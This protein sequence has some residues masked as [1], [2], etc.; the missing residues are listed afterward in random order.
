MFILPY[1]SITVNTIQIKFEMQ[2]ENLEASLTPPTPAS[3]LRD[4]QS[5]ETLASISSGSSDNASGKL[6][7]G[8]R[9]VCTEYEHTRFAT[10]G[11]R[12][13]AQERSTF[14]I[15]GD[16]DFFRIISR[17]PCIQKLMH[18]KWPMLI[19]QGE[20]TPKSDSG[21]CST[22]HTSPCD[23]SVCPLPPVLCGDAFSIATR[24]SLQI[25]NS[26]DSFS[27][28]RNRVACVSCVLSWKLNYRVA[29]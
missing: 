9:C 16:D 24:A 7:R 13:V 5:P 12:K 4:T 22:L 21:V 23:S 27:S 26:F 8:E 19:L 1:F 3:P 15:I 11:K 6:Q 2:I 14:E 10:E 28:A 17:L 29:I 18:E 20:R 25:D